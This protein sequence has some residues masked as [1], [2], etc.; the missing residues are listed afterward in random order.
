MYPKLPDLTQAVGLARLLEFEKN[1]GYLFRGGRETGNV[2]HL[3]PLSLF[4]STDP[5]RVRGIFTPTVGLLPPQSL[6]TYVFANALTAMALALLQ[7][8]EGVCAVRTDDFADGTVAVFLGENHVSEGRLRAAIHRSVGLSNQV[9]LQDY[10]VY[11]IRREKFPR[12]PLDYPMPG[13]FVSPHAVEVHEKVPLTVGDARALS[14]M[15][16]QPWI[17]FANAADARRE[18]FSG[19]FAMGGHFQFN[20]SSGELTPIRIP[21]EADRRGARTRS[22]VRGQRWLKPI[23]A[24]PLYRD[25][26][27]IGWDIDSPNTPFGRALQ[28][29][30]E[31]CTERIKVT[32]IADA[33]RM[34]SRHLYDLFQQI[35]GCTP[36][37][38]AAERRLDFA[39][40]LIAETSLSILTVA[41]RCGFSEQASLTRSLRR[42]RGIAPLELRK[43]ARV[44]DKVPRSRTSQA[45]SRLALEGSSKGGATYVD[46]GEARPIGRNT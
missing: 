22:L 15:F 45:A 5:N 10:C 30:D 20:P 24:Q 41:E 6:V 44:A 43:A 38:Y 32:E 11:V 46:S 18:P 23:N 29:I 36:M 3:Y 27:Y 25:P 34:S 33:A 37:Q 17:D 40:H 35:M 28:F 31:H 2:S 9:I 39:E 13:A 4:V 14:K 16:G 21:T 19:A 42:R 12:S 7:S 1:R 8:P 26:Q